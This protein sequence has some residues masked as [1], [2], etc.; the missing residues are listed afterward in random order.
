[1]SK[2]ASPTIDKDPRIA[3]LEAALAAHHAFIETL[4]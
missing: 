2:T 3:E 1:V 4:R